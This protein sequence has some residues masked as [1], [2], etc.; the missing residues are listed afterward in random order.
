MQPALDA[1]AAPESLAPRLTPRPAPAAHNGL[2][3]IIPASVLRRAKGFCFMS[4]AKAGFLFS[5]RAGTGVVIARLEDGAWSAPSAVGTVGAGMGFQAG[6]EVRSL[7]SLE[8][9]TASRRQN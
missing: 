1:P 3:D 9:A 4:V 2:D 7:L 8:A 5:G 6:V